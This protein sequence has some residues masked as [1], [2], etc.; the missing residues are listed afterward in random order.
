MYC[1]AMASVL[2]EAGHEVV[3]AGSIRQLDDSRRAAFLEKLQR[4]GAVT[5]VDT[6]AMPRGGKDASLAQVTRLV[7]EQAADLTVF[8]EA[9]DHLR[10][11]NHQAAPGRRLP[12]RRVGVFLR[13]T[14]YVHIGRSR[15]TWYERAR[16]WRHGRLA[17]DSDPYLFHERFLPRFGL[18]DAALCLDEVFVAARPGSHEWLPDIY[19]SFEDEDWTMDPDERG[20]V[21][22]LDAF[23]GRAGAHPLLVYYGTAQVR[24]GYI[25]LLRLAEAVDGCL[26]HCGVRPP[27]DG[28]QA[29]AD[30]LRAA[31]SRRGAL[32]ETNA[33]LPGFEAARRFFAAA[34]CVVLPYRRHYVSSGVMLQALD[35]GRPVLVPDR[36]L[37][38]WRTATFGLGRT[39][40]ERS[41][42]GLID[43]FD[44]LRRDEKASYARRIEGFMR[45]F[46]KEQ[47][48]AALGHAFG[49]GG[50]LVP[51]PAAP[52]D[53]VA[54][55]DDAAA[56]KTAP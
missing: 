53:R 11:L 12:G 7:R 47:V 36:G 40:P 39:F 28:Q 31:L 52:A 25:T 43:S 9:D 33:Y 38:A 8:T 15:E 3:L 46:T 35:A 42:S 56:G 13:S 18:L 48:E 4:R 2:Q 32:F 6:S 50:R 54:A 10:L 55:G 27:V 41:F 44:V 14:R 17:W 16:R 49:S 22:R 24:R 5:L 21:D 19:A 34:E 29:E 37:M 26:V 20:W 30:R 51:P 45:R 23:A 1:Q